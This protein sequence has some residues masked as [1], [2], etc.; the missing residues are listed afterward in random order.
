MI[1]LQKVNIKF[2][3]YSKYWFRSLSIT[4]DPKSEWRNQENGQLLEVNCRHLKL[5][6]K[7]GPLEIEQLKEKGTKFYN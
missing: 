3:A 2:K 4:Y 5:G 1:R 6:L 7:E